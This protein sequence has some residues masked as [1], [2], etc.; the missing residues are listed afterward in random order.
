MQK[1]QR[2]VRKV[3]IEMQRSRKLITFPPLQARTLFNDICVDTGQKEDTKCEQSVEGD[4]KEGSAQQILCNLCCV[5][6]V[7][8]NWVNVKCPRLK[9][10]SI[11]NL[12]RFKCA[13]CAI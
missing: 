5:Y 12:N 9:C 8:P 6:C 13:L 7:W 2:K 10:S 3:Q 4:S 1:K 11:G